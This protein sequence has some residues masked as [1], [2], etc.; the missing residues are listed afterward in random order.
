[1]LRASPSDNGKSGRRQHRLSSGQGAGSGFTYSP[2]PLRLPSH[3]S[4]REPVRLTST[5]PLYAWFAPSCIADFAVTA[6]RTMSLQNL[7][8][9]SLLP[10]SAIPP[11]SPEP[12][13]SCCLLRPQ[14]QSALKLIGQPLFVPSLFPLLN[15]YCHPSAGHHF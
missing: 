3:M 15:L 13:V 9:T 5:S 11:S 7:P 2:L 6:E 8:L 14:R 12:Q 1:M 10:L 4:Q